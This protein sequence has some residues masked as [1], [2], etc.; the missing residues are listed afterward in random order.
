MTDRSRLPGVHSQRLRGKKQSDGYGD[1]E[2]TRRGLL[3]PPCWTGRGAK[4]G[5]RRLYTG[6][7]RRH[8]GLPHCRSLVS[9]KRTCFVDFGT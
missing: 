9:L 5:P 1:R 3:A 6:Y 7:S 8:Q 2:W 4:L